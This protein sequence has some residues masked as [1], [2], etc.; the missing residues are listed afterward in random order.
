MTVMSDANQTAGALFQAGDLPGAVA[1][2]NTAVRKSPAD[3]GARVVLAEMLVLSGNLDRADVILD[4]ASQAQ[5][6]A[7]VVVAEFRQLLRADQARRQ[8]WRDG[9]V[10]EF[11]GEPTESQKRLLQA[12]VALRAGETAEAGRLAAEA[13]EARPRAAGTAGGTPIDDFRDVDDLC[14]GF[15]EVLTTTGKYFWIPTERVVSVEFHAPKRTRDLIWRRANMSVANGP[16]GEVYIPAIY[17]SNDPDL[18]SRYRLGRAT[19]WLEEGGPVR[20][21]GQRL[22]LA[23]EEAVS[24]MDLTTLGFENANEQS[25]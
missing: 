15:F 17:A 18:A 19:D 3:L 6:D 23:G 24:I 12:L 16:D 10:P 22:Y 4:A 11:L 5:P 13:E 9:R 2:A 7:A 14:A 20:G 8:L 25:Q 21:V 1:A